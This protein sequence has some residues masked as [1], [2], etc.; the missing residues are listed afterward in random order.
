MPQ[1]PRMNATLKFNNFRASNHNRGLALSGQK[2]AQQSVVLF[3]HVNESYGS[4]GGSPGA[5][6]CG[7]VCNMCGAVCNMCG[8]VCNMCGAV[9]NMCGAVCNMC[10]CGSCSSYGGAATGGSQPLR[11]ILV[12]ERADNQVQVTAEEVQNTP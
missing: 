3:G 2:A 6:S 4:S 8:A 11:V 5:M 12:Q 1:P 10:G 9:C 7:A